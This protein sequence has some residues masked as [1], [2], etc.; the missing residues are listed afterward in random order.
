MGL[1]EFFQMI[2]DKPAAG[3]KKPEGAGGAGGRLRLPGSG[4]R[5][6]R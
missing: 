6:W 5:S 1:D 4:P 2:Q 3:E